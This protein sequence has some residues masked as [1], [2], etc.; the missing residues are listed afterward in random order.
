MRSGFEPGE[1]S[2]SATSDFAIDDDEEATETHD[3]EKESDE[4][5][6][7]A[8]SDKR[9]SR[10]DIPKSDYGTLD[11]GHVWSVNDTDHV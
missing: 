1:L 3:A 2:R 7:W 6:G 8:E 5:H 9:A 4:S 11:E 10:S